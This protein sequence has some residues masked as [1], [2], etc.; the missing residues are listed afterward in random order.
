MVS[1]S[2][3]RIPLD[4]L[5]FRASRS[6]GPGGQHVN[7]SST[8]AEVRW[9]VR[10]SQALNEAQ[11][12]WLLQRLRGRLDSRGW[13]RVVESRTRTQTRNR[14]AATERLL[15]LVARALERPKPRKRSV[16]PGTERARRVA[17]KRKRGEVKRLRQPVRDD[18]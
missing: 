4:E 7:T 3:F 1:P 10:E 5:V 6:G 9:N 16:V 14:E 2:A 17:E 12:L 8:R 18:E 15:Q 11:R 13:L